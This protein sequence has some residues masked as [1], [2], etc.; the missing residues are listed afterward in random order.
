SMGLSYTF[1]SP[2]FSLAT[3]QLA[4]NDSLIAIAEKHNILTFR[5]SE[6]DVL[7][8]IGDTCK[9]YKIDLVVRLTGDCPLIDPEIVDLCVDYY[10]D[11]HYDMVTTKYNFPM[12]IDCEVLSYGLLNE[13]S[14][15]TQHKEDREHVTL[16]LW[17]NRNRYQICSID[18]PPDIDYPE[19]ILTLDEED[20]YRRMENIVNHFGDNATT[21]S[22]SEI[23]DYL[24]SEPRLIARRDLK[25]VI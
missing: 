6:D 9:A 25:A 20:D 2:S 11:R 17:K 7:G 3:S 12:G 24:H 19:Y 8:R 23:I 22:T 4:Q 13:I 18:A 16:Y 14:T 5:G 21:C 1:E 10:L 15:L